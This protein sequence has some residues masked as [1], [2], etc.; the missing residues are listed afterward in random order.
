MPNL[1]KTETIRQRMVTVYVP[2]SDMFEEWKAEAALHGVSVSRFVYELVDNAIRKK[3]TSFVPR[4]LL[5][6]QLKQLQ[7]EVEVLKERTARAEAFANES[8][9]TIADYRKKLS[10]MPA[11]PD[12]RVTKKIKD[13]F[14]EREVVPLSEIPGLIGIS[15]DD[16]KGSEMLARLALGIWPL[17]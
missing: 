6:K 9:E 8:K 3:D 11:A 1:G 14:L 2:T 7:E 5:V 16:K 15:L 10:E 12:L 13:L 4:E 17:A